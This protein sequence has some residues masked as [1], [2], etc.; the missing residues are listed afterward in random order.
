M[1]DGTKWVA[2]P[3]SGPDFE[4]FLWLVNDD[5]LNEPLSRR[6]CFIQ[7][8][9]AEGHTIYADL[10]PL[11]GSIWR[12]GLN[13]GALELPIKSSAVRTYEFLEQS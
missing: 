9:P 2:L 13:P 5:L 4:M 8:E 11:T 10:T 6:R 1:F 12:L 7:G 3:A